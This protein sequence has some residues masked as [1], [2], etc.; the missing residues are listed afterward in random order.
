MVNNLVRKWVE[1]VQSE[2]GLLPP[3]SEAGVDQE[4]VHWFVVENE[5]R[6]VSVRVK[7]T[8]GFWNNLMDNLR[9]VFAKLPLQSQVGGAVEET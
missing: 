5:G 7:G 1:S 9:G 6:R 4:Q 3:L 2:S 8:Q